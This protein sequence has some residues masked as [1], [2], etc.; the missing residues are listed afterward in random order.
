MVPA[1]LNARGKHAE[2][3]SLALKKQCNQKADGMKLQQWHLKGRSRCMG[4]KKVPAQMRK[5]SN[6]IL[7]MF[8]HMII[9]IVPEILYTLYLILERG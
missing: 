6:K 5:K 1:Q 3:Q 9:F 8:V 7:S 4:N 2:R